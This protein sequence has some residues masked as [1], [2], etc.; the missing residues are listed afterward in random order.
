MTQP[1]NPNA[2][3]LRLNDRGTE[4]L[5]SLCAYIFQHG[6]VAKEATGIARMLLDLCGRSD[7]ERERWEHARQNGCPQ[8]MGT[9]AW[10]QDALASLKA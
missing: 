4:L 10:M 8:G 6:N 5:V 1:K 9:V 3:N 2:K 7:E